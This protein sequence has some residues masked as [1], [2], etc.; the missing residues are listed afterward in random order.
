MPCRAGAVTG[1]QGS[2][3]APVRTLVISDL[4]L[5]SRNAVD[6]LR[7]PAAL[8]ALLGALD[9]VDRLVLLGD[10]LELRQ[11][12]PREAL[13]A[14]R[15]VLRAIGER[16][17]AD[18][19]VVLV[20]GNHD[21]RLVAP[22]LDWRMRDG[23]AP[24][25]LEVRAGPKASTA[26]RALARMLAPAPLDVAYPGIWLDDGVYATHGHYLDRHTTVPTYE[27]LAAGA[28]ARALRAPTSG[29]SG[30]DDYE[31]VLAPLYALLDAVAARTGDGPGAPAGA[32]VRAW[33][34]LAGDR[35]NRWR[36][37][38]LAG[39]FALG[40]AGLNRAGLGPLRAELSGDELRRAA[41]RAMGEV[42][43]RLGVGARHVVFGHTHRT[44]PLPGDDRHEWALAGGATLI[45]TGSWVYERVYVDR[46][47]GNPYWPGGAVELRAGGE[48]RLR[49]L[50]EGAD[51]AAL[52]APV[53]P[54]PA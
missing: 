53:A 31:R 5:G 20:P 40:I 13:D 29:A 30:A 7:R 44:G 41:L 18:G 36:R 34:A 48:P 45:N 28:L 52:T 1:G 42:V 23:A 14:A 12:P 6:V 24:L 38:A 21:H 11:G 17:G 54:A 50:L 43:A 51:P 16:L 26:T 22:W 25:G 27:R 39:G 10:V 19:E 46:P 3:T 15:P 35:G 49:R 4:H 2:L 37:T 9:G 32:S 8:D 33:R 47:W